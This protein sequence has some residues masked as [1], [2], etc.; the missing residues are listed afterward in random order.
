MAFNNRS[1]LTHS[2]EQH[3]HE[4]PARHSSKPTP[5]PTEEGDTANSYYS[6]PQVLREEPIIWLKG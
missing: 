2:H 3:F 4:L 6:V 5:K 1:P